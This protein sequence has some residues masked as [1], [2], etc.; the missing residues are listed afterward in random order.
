MNDTV[1]SYRKKVD[2]FGPLKGVHTTYAKEFSTAIPSSQV[3]SSL[4]TARNCRKEAKETGAAVWE[5]IHH[6]HPDVE[7]PP[8][9]RIDPNSG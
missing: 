4:I 7:I 8:E 6:H 1:H 5:A 9:L 3:K 2:S